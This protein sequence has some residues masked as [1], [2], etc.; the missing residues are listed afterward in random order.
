MEEENKVEREIDLLRYQG[1]NFPRV[2]RF[3]WTLLII[4]CFIYLVQYMYPDLVFWL[5]K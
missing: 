1:N 2:L 4:F 3:I 5:N